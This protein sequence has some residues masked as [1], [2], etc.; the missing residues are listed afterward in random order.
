MTKRYGIEH[1]LRVAADGRIEV[2]ASSM[3][4]WSI[5][6]DQAGCRRALNCIGGHCWR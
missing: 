3:P 2:T 6:A 4:A 5:T 1:A